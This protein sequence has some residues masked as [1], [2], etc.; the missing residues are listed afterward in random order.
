MDRHQP[1]RLLSQ[2][3]GGPPH[4]TSSGQTISGKLVATKRA[5]PFYTLAVPQVVFTRIC[6]PGVFAI[7]RP[8][9]HL[10]KIVR[11]S[12]RL[13]H[14]ALMKNVSWAQ[15]SALINTLY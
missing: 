7:Q 3:Q 12:S 15:D 4:R 9:L 11:G 10:V 6:S 2:Y 14:I 13:E 5:P 1:L 8:I